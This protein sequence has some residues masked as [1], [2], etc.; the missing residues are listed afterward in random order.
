M[1]KYLLL[2]VA[3][4]TALNAKTVSLYEVDNS[5]FENFIS[6]YNYEPRQDDVLE[7]FD[8]AKSGQN[9]YLQR[10]VGKEIIFFKDDKK[11]SFNVEDTDNC[12]A[13]VSDKKDEI[14]L[15]K[16]KNNTKNVLVYDVDT[17][18][19]KKSINIP[20][21]HHITIATDGYIY[22]Q[23]YNITSNITTIYR[24]KINSIDKEF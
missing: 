3:I 15:V 11:I 13:V 20:N 14:Y 5:G 16:S 8:V 1:T 18:D 17:H 6:S 19:Y 23:N 24:N 7:M 4:V 2:A 21:N 22:L 9:I 12:C 10:E